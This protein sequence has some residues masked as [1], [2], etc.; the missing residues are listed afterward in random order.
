MNQGR[1]RVKICGITR[2]VDAEQ[3]VAA[4]ADALGLVFFDKSPRSV[5]V[6]QSREIVEKIP[7]CQFV[8]ENIAF[9][10]LQ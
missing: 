9:K 5:S 2:A 4:G 7:V 6:E 8:S 3:A 1:T 10:Y